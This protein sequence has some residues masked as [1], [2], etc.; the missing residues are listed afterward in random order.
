MMR[1]TVV[2]AFVVSALPFTQ[3]CSGQAVP[4]TSTSDPRTL[5]PLALGTPVRTLG[6]LT[7][8]GPEVF[9]RIVALR[10]LAD[11]SIV[12]ADQ[13]ASEIR[14]FAAAGRF[15]RAL[16]R[17]GNGPGEF[18][19]LSDIFIHADSIFAWDSRHGRVTVFDPEGN[20]SRT[21]RIPD[22]GNGRW[23]RLVGATQTGSFVVREEKP[24]MAGA[25]PTGIQRDSI[26]VVLH[27]PD[28]TPQRMVTLLPGDESFVLRQGGR[29]SVT[30]FPFAHRG[31][32]TARDS[33]IVV[34]STNTYRLD[35]YDAD[36]SHSRSV[37]APVR[38]GQLT[39]ELVR[40]SRQRELDHLRKI[41]FY[42]RMRANVEAKYDALPRG[43]SL[44]VLTRLL[45]GADARVWVR[46][47]L[48][49]DVAGELWAVHGR[50]GQLQRATRLPDRARLM[51][52]GS[53][54]LLGVFTDAFDVQYVGLWRILSVQG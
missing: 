18:M 15:V 5:E 42:D 41:G 2:A 12:V 40:E 34:A 45:I 3:A 23:P 37:R 32:V 48:V 10:R 1:L 16:G 24:V 38:P 27:H 49:D 19:S 11:G 29:T 8:E 52:A 14:V 47:A 28:G 4:S 7:G 22:P 31:L 51:D 35:C 20:V 43:R 6:T 30:D 26:R 33:T 46:L 9:E 53:D 39:D 54:W 25:T 50:D 44:P 17:Q 21:V 13:G 36:G